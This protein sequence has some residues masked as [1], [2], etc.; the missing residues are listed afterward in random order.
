MQRLRIALCFSASGDIGRVSGDRRPGQQPPELPLCLAGEGT[1]ACAGA[2]L[3]QGLLPTACLRPIYSGRL[4]ESNKALRRVAVW[5][6][7]TRPARGGRRAICSIN[8][9]FSSLSLTW[10]SL[11]LQENG[12]RGVSEPDPRRPFE[13]HLQAQGSHAA[14]T[15][16]ACIEG[17]RPVKAKASPDLSWAALP[18]LSGRGSGQHWQT[19]PEVK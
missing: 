10:A 17:R 16:F 2:H 13:A 4:I 7:E 19:R 11:E 1:G 9:A 3:P 15:G 5:L 8:A 14:L 18:K 6:K 12:R